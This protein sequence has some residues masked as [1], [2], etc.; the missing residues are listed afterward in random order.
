MGAARLTSPRGGAPVLRFY[1]S[2]PNDHIRG[3]K[4]PS[5]LAVQAAQAVDEGRDTWAVVWEKPPEW[6]EDLDSQ[7]RSHQLAFTR[8]ALRGY[9]RL[10]VYHVFPNVT[11]GDGAP[12]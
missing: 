10:V 5:E 1:C 4:S 3:A 12:P 11:G 7:L 2:L 9:Q 8:E 6:P